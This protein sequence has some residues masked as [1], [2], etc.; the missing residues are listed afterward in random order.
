[1]PAL[2]LANIGVAMGERGT[3][4]ARESAGL[5]LLNDDFSSIV[6]AVR[7][8]R[9][10]YDNLK[11]AISYIFSVH[12]PIAGMALL[13]VL[14]KLPLV[15]LPAHIAFL[16]LIIDP[17][18]S[19]VY[20]AEPEESD[21]MRRPPRR[22]DRPLFDRTTFTM[23]LFHGLSVLAVVFLVF[24]LALYLGKG[25]ME[26]RT[27]T[28]TALVVANLSLIIANLT[29]DR[30]LRNIFADDNPA[31]KLVLAGAVVF[32]AIILYVPFFNEMF[33]F[34]FMHPNDLLISALAGAVSVLWLKLVRINDQ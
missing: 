19:T 1:A 22:L 23:S 6:Q 33:H 18:C 8:G 5:V 4:V 16:E 14:F 30:S 17:A 29:R 2:K 9:R 26:A 3:D 7:M 24:F 13:P 20:E 12:V 15:L 28:F 10:I 31:L 21:I 34:S 32:L 11:K 25:E 27:L